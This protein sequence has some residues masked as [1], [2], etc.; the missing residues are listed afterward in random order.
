M[1]ALDL[2]S[3]PASLRAG[4]AM[5]ARVED[6]GLRASQPREQAVY[7]GWLLR[8]ADGKAKRARSVNPV[9]AGALPLDEKLAHCA[10]FYARRGM[11]VLVRITPFSRPAGLDDLLAARGFTAFEDTR[12]MV[13]DLGAPV[14]VAVPGM[15]IAALD[16]AAFG[17][18]LGALHGLDAARAA[19]ER[20]RFAQSAGDGCY[21]AAMDDGRAVACGCAVFD[22]ALAGIYGM[23]TAGAHRGRGLATGLVA[24]LLSGARDRGC[25]AAYLQVDAGNAPARRMYSKF[26]FRDRYA[27][28]YRSP[29]RE[30]ST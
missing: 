11:P 7:D 21:L 27:Y 22:G 2:A 10:A 6:A 3:I 23:V 18:L 15:A 9:A 16:R 14:P 24:A 20:D 17:A 8:Y 5:L 13:A 28:W 29:P 19:V 25:A 12:V 26:G 1:S 4:D 30:D